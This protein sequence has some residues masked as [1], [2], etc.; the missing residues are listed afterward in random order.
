MDWNLEILT[1][2]KVFSIPPN[3]IFCIP[4]EMD[5]TAMYMAEYIVRTGI[6]SIKKRG[7]FHL[8]VPN[9]HLSLTIFSLL[10]KSPYASHTLWKNT[11]IFWTDARFSN[12][13]TVASDVKLQ[14]LLLQHPFKIPQNHIHLINT[15]SSIEESLLSYQNIIKQIAQNQF[16]L[17]FIEFAT[18]GRIA[19]LYPNSPDLELLNTMMISSIQ[20]HFFCPRITISIACLRRANNVAVYAAGKDKALSLEKVL[21]NTIKSPIHFLQDL[22]QPL[23]W[24]IDNEAGEHILKRNVSTSIDYD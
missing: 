9:S 18:D 1:N 14:Y 20:E 7:V 8:A 19:S 3:H 22:S 21:T 17:V 2:A 5:R 12:D 13:K 11:H 15:D 6:Q 10:A 24:I 16:D 4:G 23:F